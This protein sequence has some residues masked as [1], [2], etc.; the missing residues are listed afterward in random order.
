MVGPVGFSNCTA[1]TEERAMNLLIVAISLL[2]LQSS[3]PSMTADELAERVMKASGADAW[4]HVTRVKYT[5]VI[6][7]RGN[8]KPPQMRAHDW[9][10]KNHTDTVN[11]GPKGTATAKLNGPNESEDAKNAFG[12]WTNDTYWLMAPLKVMDPG[13]MRSLKPDETID[14]KTYHLL[15]LSFDSVGMTPTDQYN[16]YV[17]PT[18]Y[19]VRHWDY[20]PAGGKP[21]RFTWEDY[22][23]YKGV[24][25][26]TKHALGGKPVLTFTNIEVTTE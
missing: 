12:A 15:H 6:Q 19:M 22:Q 13:V 3:P 11:L 16:L 26:A 4:Q 21:T 24:K 8:G 23:D 20:I 1:Q 5:F 10:V 7:G 17:D 18:D 14:G 2:S 9:D 25:F